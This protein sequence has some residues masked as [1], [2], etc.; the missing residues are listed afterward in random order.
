MPWPSIYE[1]P[2]AIDKVLANDLSQLSVDE[3][4]RVYHD[5]HGVS[6]YCVEETVDLL[7]Q[8]L[9]QLE[10]EISNLGGKKQ[11]YD[12]ARRQD[13]NYVTNEEF[14]LKFLRAEAFD[15]RPAA[16]RI[17]RFFET[18]LELFGE[19]KLTQD[20]RLTDFSEGEDLNAMESGFIQILSRRDRSGRALLAY[21]APLR[22]STKAIIHRVGSDQVHCVFSDEPN[23]NER[24][25]TQPIPFSD[26]RCG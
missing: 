8:S 12:L 24:M 14:C 22:P 5:I 16:V 26:H 9:E 18:K 23:G 20:I 19:S 25:L 7:A 1:D 15:S 10:T 17:A 13:P 4:E 2:N 3:R 21:C 11:A 6:E